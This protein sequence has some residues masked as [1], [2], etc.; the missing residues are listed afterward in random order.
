MA[1]AMRRWVDAWEDWR[2]KADEYH[3]LDN[4]RILVLFRAAGRGRASGMELDRM[5]SQGACLFEVRGDKVRRLVNYF[6]RD[7]ALADLGLE[8]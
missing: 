6:D 3:E 7:R 8:A 5:A 1:A 2:V 4:E